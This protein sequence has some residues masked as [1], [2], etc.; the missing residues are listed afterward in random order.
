[1]KRVFVFVVA[2]VLLINASGSISRVYAA[3]LRPRGNLPWVVEPVVNNTD[4]KSVSTAYYY[5]NGAALI[6]YYDVTTNRFRQSVFVGKGLGNCGADNEWE[7]LDVLG[8]GANDGEYNDVAYKGWTDGSSPPQTGYVYFDEDE[9]ALY[10][11]FITPYVHNEYRLL[12]FGSFPGGTI[13]SQP[14]LVL[15][16]NGRVHIAVIVDGTPNDYMIYMYWV[17]SY[18]SS[19]GDFGG[20]DLWNCDTI[21]VGPNIADDPSIAVAA[22]GTPRIAYYNPIN[23]ALGYAYPFGNPTYANCGPN[24]DWRCI[25]IYDVLVS[26]KFPSLGIGNETYIGYYN[27]TTGALMVAHYVGGG[28]NCGNDW[29]GFSFDY[30]WQCDEIEHIGSEVTKMGLSLVMDGAEP[31]IAYMDSTGFQTTVKLAQPTSRFGMDVGNCGPGDL[32]YTWYCETLA[33]GQ[34]GLGSDIDMT[35]NTAGAI[36]IAYL[37]QNDDE[38]QNHLWSARQ[39]LPNYLAMLYK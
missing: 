11:A 21:L 38:H 31:V 8:L 37:E 16:S 3:G 4:I 18:G 14:T 15:D 5:P 29:N 20:D 25:T 39:Y 17:G 22:N 13:G 33:Q 6:A 12:S 10:Y 19:C 35:I 27:V 36:H 23:G 30:R 1:M 2:C 9:N 34:Y 24:N 26:G 28:G 32:F 7:C